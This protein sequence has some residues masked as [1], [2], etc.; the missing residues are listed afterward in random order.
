[1]NSFVAII[2]PNGDK[3][4]RACADALEDLHR[5]GGLTVYATAVVHRDADGALALDQESDPAP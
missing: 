3:S 1:M 2:V 5:E 4:A